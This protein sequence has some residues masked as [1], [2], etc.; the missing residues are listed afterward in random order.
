VD[1][2][3]QDPRVVREPP[4]V[5]VIIGRIEVRAMSARA[6]V[7]EPRPK[8]IG[9]PALSLEDYLERRHGVVGK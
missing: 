9:G 3:T 8:D 2:I 7:P 5:R 6:T 1:E 4:V